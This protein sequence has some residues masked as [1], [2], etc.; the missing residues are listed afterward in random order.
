MRL[1]LNSHVFEWVTVIG[2]L[3]LFLV[4]EHA[5][6]PFH[7]LFSLADL[8]IQ[9]P[10]AKHE[11]IPVWMLFLISYGIPA[12]IICVVCT[13]L[14]RR[15]NTLHLSLLALSASTALTVFATALIKNGVGRPR[16]D[17]LDR[18]QPATGTPLQGLVDIS[19]C[20]T[21]DAHFLNE[22]FRSFPSGHSSYA[23]AGLGFLAFWLAG[24]LML[25]KAPPRSWKSF[26][27]FTPIVG[28][29]M[30]AV[31]R[32]EDYRHHWQDVTVGGVMGFTIA[33]FV[34]RAHGELVLYGGSR[35][36]SV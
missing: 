31:T 30:I 18:C 33:Y 12:I 27:C 25:F 21:K 10:H 1:T 15:T 14:K 16:P 7:R 19:V 35:T 8:S 13:V 3:T 2:A 9:F 23:F 36:D 26:C 32:T 6:D 20:T 17:L 24:Q 22:G 5:I 29:A 28:A 34:S 4:L 11:Q